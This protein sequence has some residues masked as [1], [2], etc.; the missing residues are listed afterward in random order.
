M[1]HNELKSACMQALE[2]L[3]Y[4]PLNFFAG[5]GINIKGKYF[6]RKNTKGV[7]DIVACSPTGLFIACEIKVGYDKPSE[8]QQNFLQNVAEKGGYA[9]IVYDL[10]EFLK[11]L[12]DIKNGYKPNNKIN[13]CKNGGKYESQ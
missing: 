4:L 2:V 7:S 1:T 10:D 3:G 11:Y 9:F 6:P 12:E 8:M 13:I 5:G